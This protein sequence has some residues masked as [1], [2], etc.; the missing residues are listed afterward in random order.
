MPS[1]KGLACVFLLTLAIAT[2]FR[3]NQRHH[4][5][6]AARAATMPANLSQRPP[7]SQATPKASQHHRRSRKSSATQGQPGTTRS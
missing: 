1:L 2:G 7:T 6:G 3:P 5:A 4:S